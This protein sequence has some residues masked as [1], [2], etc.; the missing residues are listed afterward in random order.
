M[1]A[2]MN[3]SYIPMPMPS[4]Y[5]M[6]TPTNNN[7]NTNIRESNM[8]MPEPYTPNYGVPVSG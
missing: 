1:N 3:G 7:M 8:Y 4:P 5:T 6:S 2:N